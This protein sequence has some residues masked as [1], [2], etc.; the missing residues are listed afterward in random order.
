MRI[1]LP[2]NG[3]PMVHSLCTIADHRVYDEL[4]IMLKSISLFMELDLHVGGDRS[5]VERLPR[6]KIRNRLRVH[7]F[8][9]D[10]MQAE[11]GT[12]AFQQVVGRKADI[13]E[14]AIAESGNGM[15]VDADE[16]FFNPMWGID[17][18]GHD[19]TGHEVALSHHMILPHE[20]RK[21][22]KY[23]AGYLGAATTRFTQWWREEM[24]TSAYYEQECLNRAPRHFKTQ[25]ISIHHN[26]GW[27]RLNRC[28]PKQ[29]WWRFDRPENALSVRRRSAFSVQGDRILYEDAPLV[30]FHTHVKDRTTE[31]YQVTNKLAVDLLTR[32]TSPKH[33]TI[34]SWL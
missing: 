29:R 31:R 11:Q 9:P 21:F 34:L 8:F 5:V 17:F 15:F 20:E 23:N 10:G 27:W 28:D 13:L 26:F 22:G 14:I 24:K 12:P 7:H 25:E 4:V 6:E 32:S 3:A 19:F 33:K 30:S 2:D 16:L 1:P 18:A